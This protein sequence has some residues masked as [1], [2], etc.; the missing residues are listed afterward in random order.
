MVIVISAAGSQVHGT[1]QKQRAV[2]NQ[3]QRPGEMRHVAHRRGESAEQDQF[4]RH[5]SE[6]ADDFTR[7]ILRQAPA[8]WAEL[9]R[10]EG[11]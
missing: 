7:S 10:N 11:R 4:V 8:A 1:G 5:G 9:S 3:P 2:I 6:S